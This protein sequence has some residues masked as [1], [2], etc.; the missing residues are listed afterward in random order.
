METL[1]HRRPGR[2]PRVAPPLHRQSL[3]L[4]ADQRHELTRL[5]DTRGETISEIAR[6]ALDRGLPLLEETR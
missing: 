5:A 2:R 1:E 6:E 4:R 3:H